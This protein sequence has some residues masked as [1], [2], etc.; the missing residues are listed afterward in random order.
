MANLIH[1][2]NNTIKPPTR[3]QIVDWLKES[4]GKMSTQTV[5][6][7]WRFREYGYFIPHVPN[8][9]VGFVTPVA[10]EDLDISFITGYDNIEGE[11]EF[12]LSKNN[13]DADKI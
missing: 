9:P 4:L 13:F 3:R 7:A 2:N 10:P 5:R 8:Q 12:D 6:N 11:E 1:S